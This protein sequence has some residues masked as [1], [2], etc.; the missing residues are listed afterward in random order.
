VGRCHR[1]AEP[2]SPDRYEQL[3]PSL[4]E[5][6]AKNAKTATRIERNQKPHFSTEETEGMIEDYTRDKLTVYQLA[7]K[8]GCHRSTVNRHLRKNGINVSISGQK[9]MK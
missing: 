2:E 4:T 9:M 5:V 6:Y 8:Y 7:E 3:C 1:A